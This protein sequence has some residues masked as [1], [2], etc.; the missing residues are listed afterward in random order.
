[1]QT[2]VFLVP[3]RLQIPFDGLTAV[4]MSDYQ[5]LPG[6]TLLE[7]IDMTLY[8]RYA[9]INAVCQDRGNDCH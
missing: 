3:N 1:M 4:V 7:Q 2:K 6:T 9:S 5:V 8:C